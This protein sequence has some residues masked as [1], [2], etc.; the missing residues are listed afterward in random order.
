[1]KPKNKPFYLALLAL[2]IILGIAHQF[3]THRQYVAQNAGMSS[4][5]FSQGAESARDARAAREASAQGWAS[6]LPQEARDTVRNIQR[7]GPFPYAKDG[8]VFGNYEHRLPN[9][10]HGFYHE[11]TVV[12]LGA[13]NRGTRRVITGGDPPEVWYYTGDHYETFQQFTPPAP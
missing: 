6:F 5:P 2:V 12:T 1:M 3:S 11:Y 10:R 7:G 9:M 13:R 4:A 8:V